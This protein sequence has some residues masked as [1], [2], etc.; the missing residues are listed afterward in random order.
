MQQPAEHLEVFGKKFHSLEMLSCIFIFA[1]LM[2]SCCLQFLGLIWDM[3]YNK[4][5]GMLPGVTEQFA[6][7]FV[8]DHFAAV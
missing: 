8:G 2:V 7:L 5:V 1:M 6:P 4:T 3:G